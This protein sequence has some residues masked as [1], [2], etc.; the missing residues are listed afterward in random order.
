MND[1]QVLVLAPLGVLDT[2]PGREDLVPDVA[3]A[4]MQSQS[5]ALAVSWKTMHASGSHSR[6]QNAK[7]RERRS[8]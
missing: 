4:A 5:E 1:R 8:S 2:L 6:R 7:E 3:A